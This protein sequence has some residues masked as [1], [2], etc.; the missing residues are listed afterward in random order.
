MSIGGYPETGQQIGQFRVGRRIGGGGMGVVFEALDESL[1]RTVA[2]KVIS[3]HLADDPAFRARFTREAQAQAS[4][5]SPHVV[6]VYAHGEADDRLYIASQ[7]IPDGDLGAMLHA[8]GAPPT[9]TA[10]DL[11]AQVAEGLQ[12]AHTAGLIHRDI[13]PSNVLLRRRD[14][15]VQAYVADFGIARQVDTEATHATT[16]NIGT[17][18]Y[19]APELHTGALPGVASDVYSLGCLLWAALSGL[20]P[21]FGTSDFQVITAHFDEPVP[22]LHG[23]TPLADAVDRVLRTAMAKDP[24]DRY[25]TVE[26]MRVDLRAAAELPDSPVTVAERVLPAPVLQ[27]GTE[28]GRRSVALVAAIAVLLVVAAVAGAWFFSRGGSAPAADP[29]P[30]ASSGASA[31]PSSD[32]TGST[33]PTGG[34]TYTAQS[35]DEQTAVASFAAALQDSGYAD[36]TQSTCIAQSVVDDLGLPTLVQQGFFDKNLTFQDTDVGGNTEMQTALTTAALSCIALSA[37]A[38]PS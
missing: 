30:S 25:A 5:D 9:R 27:P 18:A 31:S 16:S 26:A 4:L 22:Q 34:P 12:V 19:M 11:I 1:A 17:P 29:G 24:A 35:G 23:G 37:T 28:P 21:Y 33:G 20:A 13:K 15:G 7:L 10:L 6:H 8:H 3:P 36:Q 14:A 2:L 38:S 32:S